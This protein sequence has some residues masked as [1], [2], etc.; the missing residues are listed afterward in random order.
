MIKSLHRFLPSLEANKKYASYSRF[1][2]PQRRIIKSRNLMISPIN[3]IEKMKAYS[4][5]NS[6]KEKELKYQELI[7]ESNKKEQEENKKKLL[8]IDNYTSK[9][10]N[11]LKNKTNFF[12]TN[13]LEKSRYKDTKTKY[14]DFFNP[15]LNDFP[16]DRN[17]ITNKNSSKYLYNDILKYKN[18]LKERKK[19]EKLYKEKIEKIYDFNINLINLYMRNKKLFISY[20]KKQKFYNNNNDRSNIKSTSYKI[21][22]SFDEFKENNCKIS[23][24]KK[25]EK[26]K[27]EIKKNDSI[28]DVSRIKTKIK[29]MKFKKIH[30]SISQ[31]F[32]RKLNKIYSIN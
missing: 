12:I 23:N 13:L 9:H 18:L 20:R 21:T 4:F 7:M 25:P 22:T 26:Q 14:N 3:Q 2:S 27:N 30:H 8:F 24:S 5:F 6:I 19:R 31:I 16:T 1:Y 11:S 15:K 32:Q 29:A 10:K 28:F 17:S